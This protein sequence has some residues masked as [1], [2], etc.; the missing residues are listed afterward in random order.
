MRSKLS[1]RRNKYITEM[2]SY[3]C[4]TQKQRQVHSSAFEKSSPY[5]TPKR[6]RSW[7]WERDRKASCKCRRLASC[8]YPGPKY[9]FLLH[10]TIN[11]NIYV[12]TGWWRLHKEATFEVHREKVE[13]L[14]KAKIAQILHSSTPSMYMYIHLLWPI[15]S[16]HKY[17]G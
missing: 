12:K 15:F 2:G 11:I 16:I 17:A 3:G 5:L 13:E 7:A 8:G 1:S 4:L 9:G 10:G 14:M 6:C